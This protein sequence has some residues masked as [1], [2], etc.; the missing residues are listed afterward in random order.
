MP[1]DGSE[2][3]NLLAL[4]CDDTI[5]GVDGIVRVRREGIA[6]MAQ[7]YACSLKSAM[8]LL[9][10]RHNIWPERFYRNAG[11][12]KPREMARLLKSRVFIAGCGALGGH[13]AAL[14]ARL[15]IGSLRLCDPDVFEESNLNRQYFCTEQTLG[16]SK[17]LACR[18]GLLGM[19]SHMEIDAREVAADPENLPELL[20]GCDAVVDCLDSI[21]RK[22]MLE[23][24]ACAK[25]I[26]LVHGAV[27]GNEGFAFGAEPGVMRLAGLY[28]YILPGN[29]PAE[30]QG[31]LAA[32]ASGTACLMASL[33]VNMLDRQQQ[34]SSPLLHLD[35]DMP[36]IEHYE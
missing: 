23:E 4:L 32:A 26:P 20:F 19:A 10:R 36:D 1:E 14:L 16:S 3:T 28:P 22:K 2:N 31:S 25:G 35:C 8:I 6:R 27:L 15:G 30:G 11:A 33:L 7:H 18:D 24:A 12:L 5:C 17:V 9:L 29:E 21:P 34:K 13:V